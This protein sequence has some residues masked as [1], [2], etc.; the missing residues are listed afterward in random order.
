MKNKNI[1]RNV[2]FYNSRNEKK[3]TTNHRLFSA[4]IRCRDVYMFIYVSTSQR[5]QT[6]VRIS[7]FNFF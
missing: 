1:K 7:A 5:D 4:V 6:S 2:Q 3:N